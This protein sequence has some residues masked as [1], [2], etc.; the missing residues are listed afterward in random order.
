MNPTNP[1]STLDPELYPLGHLQAVAADARCLG[2]KS[3]RAVVAAILA[4]DPPEGRDWRKVYELTILELSRA[5]GYSE[6]TVKA[7]AKGLPRRIVSTSR[8]DRFSRHTRVAI[9]T[10]EERSD[11]LRH[12]AAAKVADG[13]NDE[14][15]VSGRYG[16]GPMTAS[17]DGELRFSVQLTGLTEDEA[18]RLLAAY[19]EAKKAV[20]AR[21]GEDDDE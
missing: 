16:M 1:T 18:R 14:F 13:L 4:A 17:R 10:A 11:V 19:A 8:R 12:A 3:E 15:G 20:L 21:R 7:V 2:K 6:K 5:T 9:A